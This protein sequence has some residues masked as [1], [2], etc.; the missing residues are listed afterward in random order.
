M[1]G[2]RREVVTKQEDDIGERGRTGEEITVSGFFGLGPHIHHCHHG[3][4]FRDLGHLFAQIAERPLPDAT[5]AA[6]QPVGK[7]DRLVAGRNVHREAFGDETHAVRAET[8]DE[9]VKIN[10][11]R[12][13][14]KLADLELCAGDPAAPFAFNVQFAD[15]GGEDIG[16][17]AV[18]HEVDLLDLGTG[19]QRAEEVLEVRV[20]ELA[21]LAIAGV[22]CRRPV[23]PAGHENITGTPP[24][25]AK[26]HSWAA[27]N[28]ED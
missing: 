25:P 21:G 6:E 15:G 14:K 20:R 28:A 26:C 11:G 10:I 17:P 16:A 8:L 23:L 12:G 2:A 18:G 9:D 13:K 24:R 5:T 19:S 22:A 27:R 4:M 3:M 1:L 7:S